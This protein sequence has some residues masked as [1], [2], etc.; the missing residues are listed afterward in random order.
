[1]AT[2]HTPVT[3]SRPGLP[4]ELLASNAFLLKKVGWAM[5]DRLHRGLEPT[6]VN[7][8][9]YA[10]LSVLAQGTC[11][12]DKDCHAGRCIQGSCLWGSECRHNSQCSG[13]LCIHG[14]C[15]GGNERCFAWAGEPCVGC[16]ATA[17][18]TECKSLD[19]GL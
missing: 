19:E 11:T 7:P 18:Q 2:T 14:Y 16:K 10:V 9:H 12:S 15:R 5:K 17:H 6:G 3:P 4:K 8:Q 1:M 13:K